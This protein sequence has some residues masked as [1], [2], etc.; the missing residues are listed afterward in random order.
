MKSLHCFAKNLLPSDTLDMD[1]AYRLLCNII[2]KAAKTTVPRGYR[3]NY[4]LCWDAKRESL[5]ATFLQSPQGDDLILAATSLLA[6]LD[7]KWR[8]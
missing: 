1:A 5:F 6:T 4:I 2:R 8:H 7:R 3:N